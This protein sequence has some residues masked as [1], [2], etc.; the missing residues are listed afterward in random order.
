MNYLYPLPNKTSDSK[1]KFTFKNYLCT[2]NSK[3]LKISC[4]FLTSFQAS[5][6]E[7]EIS[8]LNEQSFNFVDT[9]CYKIQI[10]LGDKSITKVDE[11]TT[12]K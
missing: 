1:D 4:F 5:I 3:L 7:N 6:K 2:T 8:S 9:I 12:L 11:K 10:N